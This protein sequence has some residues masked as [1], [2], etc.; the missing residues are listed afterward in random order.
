[1]STDGR[2][3][4]TIFVAPDWPFGQCDFDPKPGR[5]LIE[6]VTAL[7]LGKEYQ[8]AKKVHPDVR[9]R[10]LDIGDSK[11]YIH[12][13][14]Q[15]K[16]LQFVNWIDKE[17]VLLPQPVELTQIS[18]LIGRYCEETDPSLTCNDAS[19]LASIIHHTAQQLPEMYP[20][21][22]KR[23]HNSRIISICVECLK[24]ADSTLS[25][26]DLIEKLREEHIDITPAYL[27]ELLND[28]SDRLM[29]FGAN[30]WALAEWKDRGMLAGNFRQLAA[31]LL[32]KSP[33]PIHLSEIHRYIQ[34]FRP[35]PYRSLETTLRASQKPEFIFLPYGFVGLSE[36]QY[37]ERWHKTSPLNPHH[38]LQRNLAAYAGK[39][40]TEIAVIYNNLYGYP[41][42]F[43]RHRLESRTS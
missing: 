34:S 6:L 17:I 15:A 21:I 32:E 24:E 18:E 26:K 8:R 30:S 4:H 22:R 16:A 12:L 31:Q 33:D 35:V 28:A 9:L 40:I 39:S 37:P 2:T 20:S 25:T 3:D 10:A 43:T 11:L 27:R 29:K 41:V 42:E 38:F 23:E 19:A 5:R 13:P 1:L 7:R 14:Q 36:R